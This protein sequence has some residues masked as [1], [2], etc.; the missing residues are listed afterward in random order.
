MNAA[1]ERL[2]EHLTGQNIGYFSREEDL[3]ICADF[4]GDV[5]TYRLYARIDAEDG[6]FQVFA[7]SPVRIPIGARPAVAETLTRINFGLKVGKFEMQYDEGEV[8]FQAAQILPQDDLDG[9]TI[10]R[11]MGIAMSMLNVYLPAILSV[12]YGNEPPKDAVRHVEPA[13]CVPDENEPGDC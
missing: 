10:H 11:L 5:G 7:Q 6:L 13:P 2:R 1:Y 3:S 9:P 4:R 8:R 12:V